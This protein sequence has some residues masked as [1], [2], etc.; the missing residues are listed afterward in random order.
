[1]ASNDTWKAEGKGSS[2]VR[3]ASPRESVVEGRRKEKRAA[4]HHI[5]RLLYYHNCRHMEF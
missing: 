2:V 1:M 5:I 4:N 3:K